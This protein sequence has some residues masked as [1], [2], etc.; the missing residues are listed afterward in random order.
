MEIPSFLRL[1]AEQRR[2]GWERYDAEKKKMSI[3]NGDAILQGLLANPDKVSETSTPE[4]TAAYN[5]AVI[6]LER[7]KDKV[8]EFSDQAT[9]ITKMR[10]VLVELKAEE[11]ISR[12][13]PKKDDTTM[14]ATTTT[15]RSGKTAPAAVRARGAK[16]LKG[17][18]KAGKNAAG[19]PKK[20]AAAKAP[21]KAEPAPAHKGNWKLADLKEAFKVREGSNR[22]KLLE[23]LA[24]RQG[25][26]VPVKD[27]LKAVYGTSTVSAQSNGKLGM[28]ANGLD[29][30]IEKDKLPFRVFRT[31]VGEDFTIG[32]YAQK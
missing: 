30:S 2:Q 19:A 1:T 6:S 22:E 10:G 24:A 32:I 12:T 21:A 8:T 3:M 4:L 13:Q 14:P 11:K 26:Q 18:A 5:I 29:A 17:A 16:N 28:V 25:K 15:N 7:P 27:L 20:V 31:R 23:A 9:A